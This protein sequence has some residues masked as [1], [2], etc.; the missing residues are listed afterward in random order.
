M[1]KTARVA[2]NA[3]ALPIIRIDTVGHSVRAWFAQ[4][5]AVTLAHAA[6]LHAGNGE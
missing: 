1:R 2:I 4:E 5:Q 6:R 3:N